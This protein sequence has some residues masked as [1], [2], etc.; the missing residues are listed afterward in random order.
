MELLVKYKTEGTSTF[1]FG[2]GFH[3]TLFVLAF[4]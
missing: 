1:R 2:P 3:V 4:I